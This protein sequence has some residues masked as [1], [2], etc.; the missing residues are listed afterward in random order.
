MNNLFNLFKGF[1][2]TFIK[3]MA[4]LLRLIVSLKPIYRRIVKFI[5]TWNELLTIPL[6]FVL[7]YFF[8]RLIRMIDPVAGAYD[9]GIMHLAIAAIAIM[10]IIHG[11]SWLLLRITFPG[12]YN[13]LD[14]I[15]ENYITRNDSLGPN[16]T[17]RDHFLLLTTF[18][19]CIISLLLFSLYLL[20]TIL[21][22][23]MF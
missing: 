18:Q 12:I 19:K 5:S 8:P 11:F 7:F 21:L 16:P 20:G 22:V 13:F 14:E 17:E 23:R 15:F 10:L 4:W 9:I 3:L 2:Q 1:W 6:G